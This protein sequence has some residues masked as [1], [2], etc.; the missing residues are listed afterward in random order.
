M[1]SSLRIFVPSIQELLDPIRTKAF[2]KLTY[3]RAHDALEGILAHPKLR[4]WLIR[5]PYSI[6]HSIVGRFNLSPAG[7]FPKP[8]QY[9]IDFSLRRGLK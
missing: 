9:L 6:S 4:I 7:Q 3:W 2:I 5:S 8:V 1:L